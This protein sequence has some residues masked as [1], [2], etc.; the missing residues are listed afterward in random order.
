[1]LVPS[2]YMIIEK[3]RIKVNGW[4]GKT[5]KMK[6]EMAPEHAVLETSSVL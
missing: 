3:A 4:F 6:I 5:E 2:M 1:V